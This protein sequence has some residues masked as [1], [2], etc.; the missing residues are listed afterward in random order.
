MP[1][2]GYGINYKIYLLDENIVYILVSELEPYSCFHIDCWHTKNIMRKKEVYKAL[3]DNR[4]MNYKDWQWTIENR[5]GIISSSDSIKYTKHM[6]KA[7]RYHA[8][9]LAFLV[10][11][12]SSEAIIIWDNI[13]VELRPDWLSGSVVEDG[14]HRLAAAIIRGDKIIA[15]KRYNQ[16]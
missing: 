2:Y 16:W 3:R 6:C 13:P 9:R 8:E 1:H 10:N 7:N 12:K 11:N 4:C 14:C 5:L 15:V